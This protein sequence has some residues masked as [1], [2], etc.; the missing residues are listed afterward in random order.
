MCGRFTLRTPMNVLAT[1]FMLESV[2]QWH[3]RFNICPSQQVPI[4][5]SR[6]ASRKR[7]C[8]T[9][10]WGLI[11]SW[12]KDANAASRAINA[13]AE[14]AAVKPT[15]RSAIK[16]RRCLVPV[17]GFFEWQ[18]DGKSKQPFYVHCAGH[19]AFAL[20]GLWESWHDPSPTDP[21]Q[22]IESF[23]I[24]TTNANVFMQSIHDRMPVI[25]DPKDHDTWLDPE[26]HEVSL[27]EP[28]LAPCDEDLLVMYPVSTYV[29]SP[30]HDS[31]VCMR[32]LD[33]A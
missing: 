27:L 6:D 29:N 20:A 22:I 24:L 21:P 4:I 7:E 11:P 33:M 19:E 16:R 25:L 12:A 8:V 15:F 31:E 23:S 17:D 9:L 10:R 3:P 26:L 1:Q 2:P 18:R 28:L 32:P 14:T 5:R 13:R 30:T